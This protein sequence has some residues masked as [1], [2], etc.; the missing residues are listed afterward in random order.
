MALTKARGLMGSTLILIAIAMMTFTSDAWA[1][2]CINTDTVEEHIEKSDVIFEGIVMSFETHGEHEAVAKFR[3]VKVW[4]G[5]LSSSEVSVFTPWG[6]AV[7][8]VYFEPGQTVLI[9]AH[10]SEGKLDTNSCWQD[11]AHLPEWGEKYLEVLARM[12]GKSE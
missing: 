4:K 5:D 2:T 9:L 7:C 6:G 1:C 3:T 11:G 8:G 10:N 12:S